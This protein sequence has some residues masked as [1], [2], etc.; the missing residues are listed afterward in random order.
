MQTPVLGKALRHLGADP[1]QGEAE[2]GEAFLLPTWLLDEVGAAV[3][4]LHLYLIGV[5]ADGEPRP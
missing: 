4:K 5:G 1:C 2:A 3:A